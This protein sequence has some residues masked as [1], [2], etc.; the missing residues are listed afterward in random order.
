MSIQKDDLQQ[1]LDVLEQR[2]DSIVDTLDGVGI[3]DLQLA[4]DEAG[5]DDLGEF[6]ADQL[7]ERDRTAARIARVEDAAG[8][9]AQDDRPS[10][11]W[12]RQRKKRYVQA[13]GYNE[14]RKQPNGKAAIDYTDVRAL[15]RGDISNG[16]CYTLLKLAAGYDEEAGE[17]SVPGFTF[18]PVSGE[19]Q[20]LCV[21]AGAVNDDAAFH[22]VN[23]GD[24]T[25]GVK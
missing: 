2:F 23:N 10:T 9:G 22:A 3:L 24:A 7:D 14:A 18:D 15:F 5:Y 13:L 21:D 25:E 4:L 8:L 16:H 11:D 20:R 1:R 6:V 19:T 12:D 17:S